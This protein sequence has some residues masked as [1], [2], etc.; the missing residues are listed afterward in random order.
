MKKF[1]TCSAICIVLAIGMLCAQ[2]HTDIIIQQYHTHLHRTVITPA[3]AKV[4]FKALQDH[5]ANS[6]SQPS[7]SNNKTRSITIFRAIR[8]LSIA[9]SNPQ[10]SIYH[11]DSVKSEIDKTFIWCLDFFNKNSKW[12]LYQIDIATDARDILIALNKYLTPTQLKYG[13]QLLR[14]HRLQ[15]QSSGSQMTLTNELG[16]HYGSLTNDTTLIRQCSN[17]IAADLQSLIAENILP[18]LSLKYNNNLPGLPAA[19]DLLIHQ[20][21]VACQL[22]QTPWKFPDQHFASIADAIIKSWQW[23]A[24]GMYITPGSSGYLASRMDALKLDL[25]QMI[26]Y[27]LELQ[28]E[29]RDDLRSLE[30]WQ[31][32]EDASSA[33]Y[34]WPYSDFTAWHQRDFSVFIK[35]ISTRTAPAGPHDPENLK[36]HLLNIGDTYVMHDGLEYFNLMPAWNWQF[37]PGVTSFPKAKI[38]E[39]QIL[40]GNVNNGKSGGT[41]MQVV[42][43][44]SLQKQQLV[45]HKFWAMHRER[46]VCLTTNLEGTF[47]G[48]ASTTLD[49]CR[50]RG[51]VTVNKPG[52]V[53]KAGSHKMDNVK[54]I[55]HA[56]FAYITMP[57]YQTSIILEL[58]SVSG[59]WRSVS[60]A[61][62]DKRVTENVFHPRID[63][64]HLQQNGDQDYGYGGYVI[65][66][67]S[68]PQQAQAIASQPEWEIMRNNKNCQAVYFNDG[69]VIAAFFTPFTLT[70]N[71]R[72]QKAISLE[73]NAPC[74]VFVEN[75]KIYVSDLAYA[76]KTIRLKWNNTVF[77]V[78]TPH[79]GGSTLA[80]AVEE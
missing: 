2:S 64:G 7:E 9:W 58:K 15:G 38:I 29:K 20:L 52:N 65:A 44:D 41:A 17:Q 77:K 30:S 33:M 46:L 50:W 18:D 63:H 80:Q 79:A 48:N 32:R 49:Q 36:G 67:A 3:Q 5:N 11:S 56:N 14:E 22:H 42:L 1:L 27:L 45:A 34:Y 39:R 25:T 26:P 55:H 8:D 31:K 53:L 23:M 12:A 35:T 78:E 24:R 59:N 74:M 19:D 43:K 28:P 68:T 40:S 47:S 69:S 75:N 37:L 16:I 62:P 72:D 13:L 73:V 21:R 76:G 10:S 51:D 70:H 71:T 4:L 66:H 57:F 54:W 61:E 6:L 60:R